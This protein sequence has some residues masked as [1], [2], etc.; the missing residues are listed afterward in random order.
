MDACMANWKNRRDI[1]IVFQKDLIKAFPEE[2]YNVYVF[3]SFI[4]Q[5]FEFS[6]SDIDILVYTLDVFLRARLDLFILDWFKVR[7]I[8]CD[9]LLYC[10]NPYAYVYPQA[11]LNGF[12]LTDYYPPRLRNELWVITKMYETHVREELERKKHLAWE[13]AFE[14]EVT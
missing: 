5:D 7:N 6:R 10:Y 13:Q 2:H 4:R 9:V 1:L 3:G 14:R 8:P 11:I 12:A